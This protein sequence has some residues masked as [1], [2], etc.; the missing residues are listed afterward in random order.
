MNSSIQ[1]QVERLRG[2][3]CTNSTLKGPLMHAQAASITGNKTTEQESLK[4]IIMSDRRG[5]TRIFVTPAIAAFFLQYNVANRALVMSLIARYSQDM[6]HKKWADNGESIK[7]AKGK[8]LDGQHRLEAVIK[9]GVSLWMSIEYGLPPETQD[10]IDTGRHRTPRDVLSI[11]GLGAWESRTLGSAIHTLI[12]VDSGGVLYTSKR[13]SNAEARAYYLEHLADIEKSLRFVRA[14]HGRGGKI[15]PHAGTLILHYLFSRKDAEKADLFFDKLF[16]GD[17][18]SRS[19]AIFHLR[20]RLLGDAMDKR[21]RSAYERYGFI[22]KAWNSF[23]S[24]REMKTETGLYSK[25]GDDF[26]EIK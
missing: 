16:V 23:R 12:E 11:E 9:A 15:F 20:N 19:S 3:C 6:V 1:R 5:Q 13:Y 22:I 2:A 10:T 17:G 8:I 25:S 7:F 14:L 4:N 21:S 26:P 18:L 24:G